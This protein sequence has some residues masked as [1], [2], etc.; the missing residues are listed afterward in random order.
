MPFSTESPCVV[1]SVVQRNMLNTWLHLFSRDH[2]LPSFDEYH[3]ER[4]EDEK[5]EIV[6]FD[7]VW[8]EG[9]PR[10]KMRQQGRRMAEV[11]GC[12]ADG[13]DLEELVEGMKPVVMPVYYECLSRCRAVYSTYEVRDSRSTPVFYERLLLPF[14]VGLRVQLILGTFKA[15]SVDGVFQRK[16]LMRGCREAS[17]FP[18]RAAVIDTGLALNRIAKQMDADVIEI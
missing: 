5:P 7:I 4:I 1:R 8:Q 13:T 17:P 3:F 14:G 6:M 11:F 2:T 16:G 9:A 15:V 10:F 18:T 12:V